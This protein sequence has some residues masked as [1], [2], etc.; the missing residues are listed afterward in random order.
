MQTIVDTDVCTYIPMYIY[1]D[2]KCDYVTCRKNK[3][4]NSYI[5]FCSV[6][7]F[8]PIYSYQLFGSFIQCIPITLASQSSLPPPTNKKSKFNLCY[9]YTHWSIS[10]PSEFSP[11]KRLNPPSFC[12]I[13]LYLQ[14]PSFLKNCTSVSFSQF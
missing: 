13:P 8:H 14:K 5:Y 10:K 2:M 4:E 11:L 9:P 12:S 3:M 1:V 6:L 7:F